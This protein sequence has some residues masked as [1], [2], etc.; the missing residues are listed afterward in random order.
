MKKIFCLLLLPVLLAGCSSITNLTPSQYPR[1]S[2][3]F[4]RV[5]AEWNSRRST[6]LPDTFKPLVMIGFNTYPMQPVPVVQDRWEAFIPVS[7]DTNFVL[8]RYK[9]DFEV[10]AISKPHWDSLMSPEYSLTV[11]DRK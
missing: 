5:E 3:G 2:S 7:G 1:E 10:N 9:F 8:Y 4:Y 6:I 11:T